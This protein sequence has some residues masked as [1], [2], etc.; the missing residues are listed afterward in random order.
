MLTFIHAIHYFMKLLIVSLPKGAV[1]ILTAN[2]NLVKAEGN[3][4]GSYSILYQRTCHSQHCRLPFGLKTQD[5][6]SVKDDRQSQ[7]SSKFEIFMK[8]LEP[9]PGI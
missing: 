1:A 8:R 3:N 7:L 9:C 2:L 4:T 5:M 6:M